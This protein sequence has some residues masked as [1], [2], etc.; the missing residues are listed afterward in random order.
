MSRIGST[1]IYE[2]SPE[3]LRAS[4]LAMPFPTVWRVQ[5]GEG[6]SMQYSMALPR[7]FLQG[8]R[9]GNLTTIRVSGDHFDA[10]KKWERSCTP[11]AWRARSESGRWCDVFMSRQTDQPAARHLVSGMVGIGIASGRRQEEPAAPVRTDGVI[12]KPDT[13][14]V[15]LD[16]MYTAARGGR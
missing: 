15:P 13:P 5:P 11:R 1:F 2:R 7:Q 8:A 12:V 14:L 10:K 6:L 9:Y 16:A 3:L 4:R